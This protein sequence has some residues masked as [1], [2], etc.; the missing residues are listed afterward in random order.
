[1]SVIPGK[2]D[3]I[4]YRN[5]PFVR[6]VAFVGYD[7]T[8]D[9]TAKMEVRGHRGATGTA[10]FSLTVQTA[11]TQGLSWSV[12][13]AGGVTTSTLTIY[14]T[15]ANIDALLPWPAN[16]QK[17]GTDVVRVHD[18]VIG[19]GLTKARWYEGAFTIREG[20]VI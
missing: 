19:S 16:G 5:A 13:T 11:G 3:F 10:D 18:L 17:A 6:T 14:I 8:G 20:V 9:T 2:L 7:F 15:E 4:A 12:A 1:M